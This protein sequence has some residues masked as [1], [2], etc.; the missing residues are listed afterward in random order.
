VTISYTLNAHAAA[1]A[2][3][4]EIKTLARILLAALHEP[5]QLD[6]CGYSAMM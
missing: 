6:R 2:A 1:N 3:Y 5:C 4:L